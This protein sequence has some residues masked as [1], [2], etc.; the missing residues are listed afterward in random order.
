MENGGSLRHKC[1]PQMELEPV[2]FNVLGGHDLCDVTGVGEGVRRPGVGAPL[3][4]GHTEDW[5]L[6]QESQWA[7][8]LQSSELG[9]AAGIC[10]PLPL[11]P[12]WAAFE[13][14]HPAFQSGGGTSGELSMEG[15]SP[16][17]PVG[18]R[19]H[20]RR[21]RVASGRGLRQDKPQKSTT[22]F[23]RRA[24]ALGPG[25]SRARPRGCHRA[26]HPPGLAAAIDAA[27]YSHAG[28]AGRGLG[29]SWEGRH[30]GWRAAGDTCHSRRRAG[31][32]GP[33]KCASGSR[34]PPGR[35][36]GWPA[37]GS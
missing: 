14:S 29:G 18:H 36:R 16:P 34:G 21:S 3:S 15:E 19:P 13:V 2:S 8:H 22:E 23:L 24:L 12:G 6:P 1:F 33:G 27:G 10:A 17:H 35:A 32:L 7:E 9:M 20:G 37:Q 5:H 31:L 26:G 28:C 30:S 11:D 25:G 4:R